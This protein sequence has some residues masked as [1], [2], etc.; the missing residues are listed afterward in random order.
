MI[1][2]IINV[3]LIGALIVYILYVASDFE[4]RLKK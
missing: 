4:N 1:S 3:I 2:G